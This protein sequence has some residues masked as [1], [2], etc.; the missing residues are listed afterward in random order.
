MVT[1]GG[2]QSARRPG[3]CYNCYKPGHWK[4][5]CPEKNKKLSTYSNLLSCYDVYRNSNSLSFFIDESLTLKTAH[6]NKAHLLDSGNDSICLL[7]REECVDQLSRHLNTPSKLISPVGKLSSSIHKWKQAGA[8]DYI[9]QVIEK[10]YG[11]PFK[12]LPENVFLPNNK[13]SRD[14]A[15]FV[16]SEISKLLEKGCISKVD[17]KPFVI[18]PLT[19][20]FNRLQKPR[21]V[22]DCRHINSCIHQFKFKFEDA[23]VARELFE[24]GDYLFRYDLK[25]AYHHIEIREEHKQYLG[26]SWIIDGVANYFVFNVLPFGIASAGYIFTKVLKEVVKYWRKQGLK[27]IMYLDDGLSGASDL[28]SSKR[29]SDYIRKSVSDFGFLIAED[30]CIWY[31]QQN[32]IWI[33]LVWDMYL[34]KV[35]ITQERVDRLLLSIV[36]I[37]DGVSKGKILYRA[38]LVDCIVGQIISMQVVFGSLVRLRTRELYQCTV[39]RTSWKSLVA[40]TA[41]AVGE[42]RYWSNS[43][44]DLNAMGVNLHE[45]DLYD[46]KAYTDASEIGFGGFVVPAIDSNSADSVCDSS[47]VQMNSSLITPR[48]SLHTV[49]GCWADRE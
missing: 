33:G 3:V 24:K 13:S 37:L 28:V 47:D 46:L 18:N 49:V 8:T 10:G 43:V 16:A 35:Q 27:I 7:N 2:A 4:F 25:S 12:E 42:L 17:N 32:L 20:A 29:A 14:N 9:L 44:N 30:K 36:K 11:I 31:P 34:G 22:L 41:P 19:V 1:T 5:E 26:F 6:L 15:D 23:S 39:L 48:N 45:S 38:K 40:L 21:L